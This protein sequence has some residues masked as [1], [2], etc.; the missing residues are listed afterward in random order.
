LE[1]EPVTNTIATPPD[2]VPAAPRL[3][4]AEHV[5]MAGSVLALAVLGR[6]AAGVPGVG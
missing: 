3:L 4:R 2:P 6:A 1:A 5:V